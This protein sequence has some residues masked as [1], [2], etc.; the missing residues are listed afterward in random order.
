MRLFSPDIGTS[1]WPNCQCGGL[2][3]D[4]QVRVCQAD[5]KTPIA[6]LYAY[7]CDSLANL[8]NPKQN[9]TVFP[10]IAAGWNQTGG[11]MAALNAVDYIDENFGLA[12]VSTALYPEG[13]EVPAS[14]KPMR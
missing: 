10:A 2:T 8:L 12:Q 9:Y 5:D 14:D 1:S 13:F 11:R 6:G 4:D 3:V 7:G